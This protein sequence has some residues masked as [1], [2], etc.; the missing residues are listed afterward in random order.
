MVFRCVT[1][2]HSPTD[3]QLGFQV[4]TVM[5]K[6]TE[7]SFVQISYAHMLSFPLCKFSGMKLLDHGVDV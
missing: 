6:A 3:G 1:I 2:L 7:N 4:G 5:N